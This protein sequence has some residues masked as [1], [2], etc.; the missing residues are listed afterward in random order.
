MTNSREKKKKDKRSSSRT[1]DVKHDE[2]E[3]D[4]DEEE[5]SVATAAAVEEEKGTDV[6]N[7]IIG[8][9]DSMVV[10][11]SI[12]PWEHDK[13]PPITKS[14]VVE[15]CPIC[16][17]PPEYCE[18]GPSWDQC[19]PWVLKHYPEYYPELVAENK[20][21]TSQGADNNT[22]TDTTKDS[23]IPTNKTGGGG[24]KKN[25]LFNK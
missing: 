6:A 1:L 3:K 21:A 5:T 18:F 23:S 2:I 9:S 20:E 8:S 17:L 11:P 10:P 19:K 22:T 7:N 4:G 12:I 16:G 24:K 25:R 14:D 13:Q 15:Y